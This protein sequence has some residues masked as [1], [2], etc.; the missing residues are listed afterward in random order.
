MSAQRRPADFPQPQERKS[1]VKTRAERMAEFDRRQQEQESQEQSN[2]TAVVPAQAAGAADVSPAQTVLALFEQDPESIGAAVI[3]T[4]PRAAAIVAARLD[5]GAAVAAVAAVGDALPDPSELPEVA[6]GDDS[7]LT[8]VQAELRAQCDAAIAAAQGAADASVWTIGRALDVVARQRLHRGTHPTL[9][10]YVQDVVGKAYRQTKRWRDGWP[11]AQAAAAMCPIGQIAPNEG[12]VRE[13]L[14]AEGRYGRQVAAELYAAVVGEAD[15]Q[16]AR[17]T[18]SMLATAREALPASLPREHAPALERAA[19]KALRSQPP[20]A[21]A[22]ASA[23]KAG[24]QQSAEPTLPWDRPV[25]VHE[26]LR[27]HMS[28]DHRAELAELLIADVSD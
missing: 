26:L 6:E 12:Q 14:T 21:A 3:G 19:V 1:A 28:A 22:K 13:L 25:A 4:D 17:V 10:A 5:A 27:E 9:D 2:T 20:A 18:A 23:P 15:K 11:L 7:E 16:K 8:S 24:R